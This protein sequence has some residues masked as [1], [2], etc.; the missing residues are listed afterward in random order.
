MS[1]QAAL[2]NG[3]D[4]ALAVR[5]RSH[6]PAND[7]LGGMIAAD[8]ETLLP[9]DF[10]TKVDRASMACGLEVRPPLVDHEFLE[11]AAR[12]PSRFKIRH[13]QT[14]W[15]F[16]QLARRRLPAEIL[17]RP[18]QGFEVP[19]DEWLRGPLRQMFEASVLTRTARSAA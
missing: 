9:D 14:K 13:G 2:L 5:A 6:A 4:P 8:V 19:V 3:H 18:K 7:P 12:I 10:L 16:K 11:L 15:I 1:R 17:D